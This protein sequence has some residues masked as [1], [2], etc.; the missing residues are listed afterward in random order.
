MGRVDGS[1]FA[2]ERPASTGYI[3]LLAF[4]CRRSLL[5]NASRARSHVFRSNRGTP[6]LKKGRITGRALCILLGALAPLRGPSKST[7][8]T[9]PGC[10]TVLTLKNRPPS[11]C[12]GRQDSRRG[13]RGS[14]PELET[15]LSGALEAAVMWRLGRVH[16]R[17]RSLP[18]PKAVEDNRSS[19]RCRVLPTR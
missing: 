15:G 9:L 12:G 19:R 5:G 8:L 3:G 1:H 6:R 4:F 13:L 17:A 11:D 10:G 16:K 14:L 18:M 2:Q 7:N